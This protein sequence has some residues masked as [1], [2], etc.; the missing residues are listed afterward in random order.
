MSAIDG[1][2]WGNGRVEIRGMRALPGPGRAG[3]GSKLEIFCRGCNKSGGGDVY[4]GER[5]WSHALRSRP[6]GGLGGPCDGE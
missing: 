1:V 5:R 4:W 6:A 2:G 3:A